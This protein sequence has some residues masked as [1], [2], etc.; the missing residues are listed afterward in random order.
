MRPLSLFE[1]NRELGR[2]EVN[3]DLSTPPHVV[4]VLDA[5]AAE[6]YS[7][8]PMRAIT[9]SSGIGLDPCSNNTSLINARTKIMLPDNGLRANWRDHGLVWCNPPYDN[10]LP[11]VRK[12][13]AEADEIIWLLKQDTSTE[14]GNNLMARAH[15]DTLFLARVPFLRNGLPT[16]GGQFA[17]AAYYFGPRVDRF[18][19]HFSVFGPSRRL[20][21][22][23]L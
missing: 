20:P 19:A 16:K 7:E 5:F 12:G 10:P 23:N 2:E 13:L 6:S 8:P 9:I 11:W 18:I 22:G 3:N 15:A 14:W 17:S 1:E 4:A 21:A